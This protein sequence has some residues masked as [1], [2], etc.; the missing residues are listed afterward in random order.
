M[1]GGILTSHCLNR[2]EGSQ[3]KVPEF[4]KPSPEGPSMIL[5]S[6]LYRIKT[7]PLARAENPALG[8]EGRGGEA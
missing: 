7:Q 4:L 3:E 2:V 6:T 1:G 5:G 8:G